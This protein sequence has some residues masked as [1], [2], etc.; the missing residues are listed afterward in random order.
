MLI[1]HCQVV[2]DRHIRQ[3]IADGAHD[4]EAIA[5][6]CGAGRDCGGCL[7]AVGRLLD[8]CLQ[9]PLRSAADLTAVA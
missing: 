3:A 4:E 5:R 8:E 1:C 6:L 9:C 7:P 2:N